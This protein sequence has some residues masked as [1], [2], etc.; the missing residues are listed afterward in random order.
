MRVELEYLGLLVELGIAPKRKVP[1]ISL[2]MREVKRLEEALGHD[3]KAVEVFIR[4]SLKAKGAGSLAPFVHL[5]LTSEDTNSVAYG[6]LLKDAL[7]EVMVPEYS[8]LAKQLAELSR[9]EAR[10]VMVARTHG[11]PAVPTTFGKEVAVFAVRLAERVSALGSMRPMAKLSGAVGTYA[12]FTLMRDLDWP[13]VLG[14]F[15]KRL[16]LDYAPYSTQVVPGERLSDILH[17]VININQL[18]HSLAMDL[19]LYQT[20]DYVHI[21]R[22]GKVSSSTMP[23]KVNPVDLENAEGQAEVSNSLLSLLA[24]RLQ[25]TRMQRDLSDS[26]IR[27]MLGQ[28]LVHSLIA[29]RRLEGSV[30]ALVVDRKA[31][32]GDL[33]SHR[34]VLAEAV[35][36]AMR[37]KGD[38]RGYERVKSA[39]E[40]GKFASLAGYLKG[41]DGYLG[42]A[43]R[44]ALDCPREVAR[45]LRT[46]T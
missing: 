41:T 30:S 22:A 42:L 29:C 35:Q 16:G 8:R 17:Y 9:R 3:V 13:R 18:M 15:V 38:E 23:Q 10:T 34:E 1:S 14:D 40:R 11:R 36:V 26:V 24:Y 28:A 44:L 20:L 5:G 46:R 45:L 19:W 33:A 7:R 12:S 32:A 21:S 31:M 37:L 43:P 6:L 39:L 27:R 25:T 2:Q 4:R